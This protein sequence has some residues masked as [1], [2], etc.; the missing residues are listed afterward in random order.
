MAATTVTSKGQV[1]IPKRVRDGL[2]LKAGSKVEI[3]IQP[4]R[5]ATLKPAGKPRQ[6][7]YAKRIESV[8]GTLKLG[9]T[10]DEFMKLMRGDD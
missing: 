9:M 4:G 1:T 8:R 2:G 3:E 6:S 7:D 10:T 5:V